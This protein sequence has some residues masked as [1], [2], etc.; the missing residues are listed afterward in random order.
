[1]VDP[2]PI[3]TIVP[4][5]NRARGT[6]LVELLVATVFLGLCVSAMLS[7]IAGTQSKADVAKWRAVALGFAQDALASVRSQGAAGTLAAGTAT[8][9]HTSAGSPTVTITKTVSLASGFTDLYAVRILATFTRDVAGNTRTESLQL[10]TYV[11]SPD[12]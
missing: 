10:D 4:S 11:R 2:I 3:K 5:K 7:S 6:T 9:S 1:M 12:E 8:T